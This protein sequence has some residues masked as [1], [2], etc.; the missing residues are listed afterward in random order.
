MNDKEHGN[1]AGKSSFSRVDIAKLFEVIDLKPGERFLDIGCGK[2]E[3]SLTA[4]K[5]IGEH[6]HLYAIDVW[7]DGIKILEEQAQMAGIK[8][9]DTYAGDI[10]NGIPVKDRAIDKCLVSMVLHGL[11][12]KQVLEATL[13]EIKRVLKIGGDLV[14]I[15]WEKTERP[16]GPPISIRLAQAEIEAILSPYGFKTRIVE[17]VGVHLCMSVFTNNE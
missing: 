7:A 12:N 8:N 16:P 15:E 1:E 5:Y 3:Y 2:G 11:R 6:G 13:E 17:N 9:L 4:A 14:I 10:S